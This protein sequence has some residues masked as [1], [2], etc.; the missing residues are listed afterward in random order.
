MLRFY[1]TVHLAKLLL[2]TQIILDSMDNF[3]IESAL[4]INM[5]FICFVNKFFHL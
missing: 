1:Q 3:N 5:A 2:V 4:V